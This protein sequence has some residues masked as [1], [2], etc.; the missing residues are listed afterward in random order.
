[1]SLVWHAARS[2]DAATL[3]VLIAQGYDIN[4]KG[5]GVQ[6]TPLGIAVHSEHFECVSILLDNKVD[7]MAIDND[8]ETA[9]YRLIYGYSI[10]A[11]KK[12]LSRR[13]IKI[14][15]DIADKMLEMGADA[16]F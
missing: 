6:M 1:M 2:G 10:R 11:S 5:V 8:R 15:L 3:Q 4:E 13:R 9:L 14:L 7:V 16:C 12:I